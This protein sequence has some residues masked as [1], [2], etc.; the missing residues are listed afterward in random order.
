M[1]TAKRRYA[2]SVTSA[3]DARSFCS[4]QLHDHFGASSDADGVVDTAQ[5]IVSELV[6][7]AVNAQCSTTDLVLHC[8]GDSLRIS[9]LD[10]GH[11][12]PQVMNASD[13]D[14][15]GR[16]LAIINAL[17]AA[18]GVVSHKNDGKQVW[19]EVTIPAAL[20]T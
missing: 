15:H 4:E 7:N 2:C 11:G 17:A 18:W 1:W 19:A 9:V 5:L 14:E 6:T 12:I 16:G 20:V 10:D 13:R 3:R 8:E